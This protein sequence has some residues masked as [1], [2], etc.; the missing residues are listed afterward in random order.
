MMAKAKGNT[1]LDDYN[2]VVFFPC[3][4]ETPWRG[5]Y[6][7]EALSKLLPHSKILCIENPKDL[8]ISLI[9]NPLKWFKKNK[10][11]K[12]KD[13]LFVFQ[14]F[15]FLNLHIAAIVPLLERIN[16]MWLKR[17]LL[18]VMHKCTFN[19]KAII[20]WIS[21]PFHEGFIG[22]FDEELSI[23]DCYDEHT[24][25]KGWPI[26]RTNKQIIKNEK[27]LLNKVDLTFV[28]SDALYKTK[29]LYAKK[30]VILPNAVDTKHFFPLDNN[31]IA[32]IKGMSE[33]SEPVIG[34]LG[35]ISDM[36]DIP[37][38]C[39]LAEK[40]PEWSFVLI[41]PILKQANK[42]QAFSRFIRMPNIHI[43]G[44]QPYENL[45]HYLNSFDVCFLPLD[46]DHSFNKYCSPL[47]LY[48]YL[49]TGKPIV[50]TDIPFVRKFSDLV[51]I[52][53]NWNDIENLIK[54][55]L[56]EKSSLKEKRIAK[57]QENTWEK[58]AI[59]MLT[60]IRDTIVG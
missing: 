1:Y 10:T 13:N 9:K 28:V 40:H 20:T 4:W 60:I 44:P 29:N 57:A 24:S 21:D 11:Y 48:E 43:L 53:K 14:P 27:R 31:E 54:D 49:A 42:N 36:V 55:C 34:Y 52:G 56:K 50:S 18:H 16:I 6:L 58:R 30:M 37:M 38:L 7:I 35:G 51:K 47:K 45:V 17:Q 26:I 32:D 15:I 46:I 3:D 19:S 59:E 23:Y 22:M 25:I 5:R 39:I 33:L 12:I 41:G 8:L 2:F